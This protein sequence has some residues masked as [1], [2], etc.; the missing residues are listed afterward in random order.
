VP[1]T[2]P[3]DAFLA[4]LVDPPPIKSADWY[5]TPGE[6]AAALDPST[7]Q[8]P[9]LDLIDRALVDVAEGRCKRLIIS[10]PPQEGKSQRASRRFPLWL[11]LR[12]PESR[13]A[14][15]SYAHSVARG[16]GRAIRN[17]V[18][19]HADKLSVRIAADSQAADDWQVAG[20]QG[21]VYCTGVGGSL[22]GKP[23]DVLIV[24]DPVKDREQANSLTYREATWSWWT[25]VALTRLAPGAPVVIIMTRWHEDDLAGRV[26]AADDGGS[27]RVINIPAQADHHPE[28]G[29]TDQLGREPGVWLTSTRGRT[30][31]Q[32]VEKRTAVGSR[33]FTAL[34]QGKPSPDA[35]DVWQR[36]WW[37][38][39]TVPLWTAT[40]GVYRADFD[41][42]TQSWDMAFKG[43]AGSDFVVGQVWGRKGPDVYL[44]DQVH[45][46][47]SFTAT[48][49]A[50]ERMRARWPQTTA[51]LVEDKAN[52]T[53]V[54]DTLRQRIAGL[55]PVNPTDSKYARATAVA[56]FIEAGSVFLPDP[57]VA[58]FD[59]EG[60]VDEAAA[61][62]NGAHDDQVDAT[63]Q[64]LSRLLLVRAVRG[65]R[66]RYAA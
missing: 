12:N 10:M 27:W 57:S 40:D 43:T 46:R 51:L 33:T 50:V 6:M 23:V 13:I 22:T 25:D 18:Y 36:P 35:G 11:L 21:G 63:S 32:W 9:A 2:D 48:L 55:I 47:L 20:H 41:T 66:M 61:F 19:S 60:L 54:I 7:V 65:P 5:A 58:L 42:L 16:W 24:D 62:P 15:A 49:A 52:G 45:A 1:V 29:E 14:I 31:A 34:Y 8:T 38:R 3:F 39:Y 37:A 30:D 17:D 59:V 44:L 56:P 4:D 26:L 28:R 53:A 64:A